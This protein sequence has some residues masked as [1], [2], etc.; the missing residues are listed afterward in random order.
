[1]KKSVSLFSNEKQN[2]PLRDAASSAGTGGGESP[3]KTYE[4]GE[5]GSKVQTKNPYISKREKKSAE[6]FP[7]PDHAYYKTFRLSRETQLQKFDCER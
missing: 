6:C 4:E 1:M 7:Q 3:T 5:P 2:S